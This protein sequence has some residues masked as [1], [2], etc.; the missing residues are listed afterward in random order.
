MSQTFARYEPQSA[1]ATFD[2]NVQNK[3][4]GVRDEAVEPREFGLL[5]MPTSKKYEGKTLYTFGSVPVYI[6]R[7]ILFVLKDKKWTPMSLEELAE[8][9][10][11]L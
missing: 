9:S 11:N 8:Y 10:V 5:F 4:F 1:M 3:G 7:G 2:S 6:D